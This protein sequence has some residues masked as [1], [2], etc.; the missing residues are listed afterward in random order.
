MRRS[1]VAKKPN[2]TS[3]STVFREKAQTRDESLGENE[4]PSERN[5]YWFDAAQEQEQLFHQA[6]EALPD[7][8]LL[9]DNATISNTN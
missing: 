9:H 6:F 4:T 1:A 7:A 8:L 2:G 3:A 5:E